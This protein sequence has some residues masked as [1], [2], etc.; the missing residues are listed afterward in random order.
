MINQTLTQLRQLKLNGMATA[1]DMQTEQP[2]NYDNLSFEE[3]IGLLIDSEQHEREQR[4]QQRLLKAAKLKINAN[5][6]DIDYAQPR[7]LNQSMMASLLQCDWINKHQNL[8]LTGPCGSGKTYL[9]C[10]LAH[11]ACTKGYS[12]KYYR[13]S[14]LMLELTQAKADGT[15]SKALQQLAKLD[16][17][18]M[19]DWGL[20]PLNAAQRNDLM[21]IMDDRNGSS[22]TVIISQLPTDQWY[23]SIGDNTLADAILDRLMHNAHRINLKGESMRKLQSELTRTEHLG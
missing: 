17:L 8:L 18:I 6:R 20:E 14:R 3:R 23:Q 13:L 16:V 4:K 15:Y 1:L 7:G 9:A 10:A 2:G 12:A 22:S 19:D 21:E 11:T 5:A